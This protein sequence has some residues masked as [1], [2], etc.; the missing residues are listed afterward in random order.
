MS[1]NDPTRMIVFTGC[2]NRGEELDVDVDP[3]GYVDELAFEVKDPGPIYRPN[4]NRYNVP[5]KA[6]SIELIYTD[7][8]AGKFIAKGPGAGMYVPIEIYTRAR[9]KLDIVVF[10]VVSN[11]DIG[12]REA[13]P[14]EVRG[15]WTAA[16]GQKS[17]LDGTLA[18]PSCPLATPCLQESHH[19]RDVAPWSPS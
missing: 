1:L 19:E 6:Q 8:T 16:G 13:V 14:F 5:A 4:A 3:Q 18:P 2:R 12:S 17:G 10:D 9:P 7:N 15:R 11:E